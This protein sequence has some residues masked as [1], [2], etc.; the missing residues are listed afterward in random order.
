MEKL[1]TVKGGLPN[2]A[3][4]YLPTLE[5]ENCNSERDFYISFG[6]AFCVC[7]HSQVAPTDAQK[8]A[9]KK[10]LKET[11]RSPLLRFQLN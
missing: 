11:P 5:C 2:D 6:S 1:I 10:L 7:C 4:F 9:V 3:L 8:L